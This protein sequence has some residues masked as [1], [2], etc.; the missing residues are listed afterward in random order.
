[1]ELELSLHLSNSKVSIFFESGEYF[2]RV[3]PDSWKS[4]GI[5]LKPEVESVEVLNKQLPGGIHQDD[6]PILQDVFQMINKQVNYK[7]GA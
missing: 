1:M 5:I 3:Q 2:V 7:A 4:H 6:V